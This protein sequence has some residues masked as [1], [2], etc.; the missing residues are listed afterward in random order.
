MEV[1]KV[2]EE[3]MI[4]I[5]NT[6]SG[7]YIF[8]DGRFVFVN[9]TMERMSGYT[10]EELLAKNYLELVTP[11]F[12]DK[13]EQMTRQALK[14]DV[15]TLPS[16]YELKVIRKNGA[17]LWVENIPTLVQY[18]GKTAIL[19]NVVDITERKKLEEE[20]RRT[21]IFYFELGKAVN[22]SKR[23]SEF[24]RRILEALAKVIDYDLANIL[25]YDPDKNVLFPSAQINY[26]PELESVTIKEQK[27]LKGERKVGA[28]AAFQKKPVFVEDVKNHPLT[29]YA[30][31][32]CK[33]YN[34]HQIFAVPLV[35]KDNLYGVLE[36]IVKEGKKLSREDRDLL[37]IL[38]DQ[39]ASGIGKIKAEEKLR[40]LAQRDPVTGLYNYRT[41]QEKLEEQK[42]RAKRYN[43]V[44]S[45]IY[46]DIDDFK[47]CND[48]Y[49]HAE[50]DKVL[51]ILGEILISSLRKLD[52]AYRYGGE[53]FVI[54]LPHTSKEEAKEVAERIQREVY[55]KLY[56]EY[57]ITLSIGV[58]D[59]TINGD[60]IGTADKT[61]Y[62]AKREGK[63]KIKIAYE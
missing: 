33:K 27:V 10:R 21:R 48:I 34:L 12:R 11:E 19:G 56:S 35:S 4:F 15:S 43:E 2:K 58:A 63:N 13:L 1:N 28:F 59:S 24:S 47:S 41:L 55:R 46:L 52:S 5:E 38:S 16:R 62:E 20:L 45:V 54:I 40:F 53:E 7:I 57:K 29:Q 32:L 36:V 30:L 61:M 51:R 37:T 49:G 25:V 26:P 42:M 8:Q 3:N 60:V 14:G 22:L 50:G 23:I 31:D 9:R 18:R 6:T 17:T 44:Y 39:I